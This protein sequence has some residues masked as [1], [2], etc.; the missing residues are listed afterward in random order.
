MEKKD[1][2]FRKKISKEYKD[3]INYIKETKNFTFAIITIFI[4][5]I[6]IGF[7]I[8]APL[9]IEEAITKFIQELLEKTKDMSQAELISFIFTNNLQSSFFG[10]IF[11]ILF[12]IFPIITSIVNGYLLG[13]VASAVTNTES[14]LSLWRILPHGIF[15]LPAIFISLGL[16]LK[17]SSF[18]FQKEK[19]K[20]L[21]KYLIKSIKTFILIIIPL[22]II[23]AIIE[24]ILIYLAK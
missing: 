19:I 1:K 20:S 4:I 17:I 5:F 3:S 2:N 9:Q 22:L 18:V 14:I 15:E 12:G 16:G 8:P 7:F 21:K 11:G 10:M 23:A 13:Y 6:L 24:G